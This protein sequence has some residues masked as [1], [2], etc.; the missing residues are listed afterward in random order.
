MLWFPAE[1]DEAGNIQT[2]SRR[3]GRGRRRDIHLDAFRHHRG[4]VEVCAAAYR[5]QGCRRH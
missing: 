3:L 2:A 1:N 4:A 5:E